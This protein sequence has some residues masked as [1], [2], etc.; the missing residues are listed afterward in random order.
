MPSWELVPF[1]GHHQVVTFTYAK[2]PGQLKK[3]N[4]VSGGGALTKP[5]WLSVVIV[6]DI[7]ISVGEEF[8]PQPM[9]QTLLELT[10]VPVPVDPSIKA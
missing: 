2:G 5:F 4:R 10:F 6:A 8:F 7:N 9:L 1:F 3:T